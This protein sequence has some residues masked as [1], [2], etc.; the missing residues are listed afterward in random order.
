M[1]QNQ[2]Y[3]TG[4]TMG[5]IK[6]EKDSSLLVPPYPNTTEGTEFYKKGYTNGYLMQYTQGL[7]VKLKA[8]SNNELENLIATRLEEISEYMKL[9]N[10]KNRHSQK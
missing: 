2:E 1:D 8:S 7:S 5:T 9:G 10:Q 3:E 6:G 4:Y